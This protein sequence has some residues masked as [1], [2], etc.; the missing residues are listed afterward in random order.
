MPYPNSCN[1][2]VID[3]HNH[4]HFDEYKDDRPQVIKR[5]ASRCLAAML[6]VGIDRKDSEKALNIARQ[7][8][9]LYVSIGVHPQ[10][11]GQYGAGDVL[12]LAS[13][14]RDTRVVAVGETGFD[15]YRTPDTLDLQKELFRAHVDLARRLDLPLVIHT[16]NA[17]SI[18]LEML[19]DLDAWELGGVIHCFSGDMKMAEHVIKKGF[20]V[21]IPGVIT[22]K[23]AHVLR[24]VAREVPEES[25]LVETDAP[26]LAPMPYRGK[27]NE[28]SYVVET[29]KA[30]SDIREVS[31]A[32]MAN[33]T[34][35]NFCRLFLKGRELEVIQ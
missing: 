1:Y 9:G 16:R 11:A 35:D 10:N 8:K 27:R 14:S 17:D 25:L 20:V 34:A 28:P 6:L 23:K 18:L 2:T 31:I 12:G 4:I 15:L 3:S 30:V 19:D 29:L 24:E 32:H 26:Y 21:S 13:L 33:V 7:Y 22:F 5:S